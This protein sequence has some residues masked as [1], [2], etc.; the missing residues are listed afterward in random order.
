MSGV[1]VWVAV[2]FALNLDGEVRGRDRAGGEASN[3]LFLGWCSL[4]WRLY[5]GRGGDLLGERRRRQNAVMGEGL[6]GGYLGR[7][8]FKRSIYAGLGAWKGGEV[9][10]PGRLNRGE[11][12]C[13]S[14]DSSVQV[15][16]HANKFGN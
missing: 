13:E 6:K 7:E 9:R 3:K 14:C 16:Y 1:G 5:R 12:V 2:P 11:W 8:M 4:G 10:R 15:T